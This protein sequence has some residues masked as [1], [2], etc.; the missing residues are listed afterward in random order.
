MQGSDSSSYES[1]LKRLQEIRDRD[2]PRIQKAI[3][4]LEALVLKNLKNKLAETNKNSQLKISKTK[5]F[6]EELQKLIDAL[7]LKLSRTGS[8]IKNM[9][10]SFENQDFE[11]KIEFQ[12]KLEVRQAKCEK[13]VNDESQD[14][15]QY[16]IFQLA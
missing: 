6:F 7:N 14:T 11:R 13:E 5:K 16:N 12:G 10:D 2:C 1:D 8:N 9:K 15:I 4:A 3:E